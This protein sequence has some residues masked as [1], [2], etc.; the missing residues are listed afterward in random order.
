MELPPSLHSASMD[1][2]NRKSRQENE[3]SVFRH[4]CPIG[5]KGESMGSRSQGGQAL[6]ELLI[7]LLLLLSFVFIAST[8]TKEAKKK[9]HTYQYGQGLS[10]SKSFFQGRDRP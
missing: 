2:Q 5:Q 4:H 1:F 7:S 8:M 3:I 6:V 10:T 9:I